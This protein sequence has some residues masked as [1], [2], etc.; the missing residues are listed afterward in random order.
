M[1]LRT[2]SDSC[3][4]LRAEQGERNRCGN[5]DG[6][7]GVRQDQECCILTRHLTEFPV[8]VVLSVDPCNKTDLW[9]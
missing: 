1:N 5:R 2:L 7:G 4:L 3:H 6:V 8:I 9:L